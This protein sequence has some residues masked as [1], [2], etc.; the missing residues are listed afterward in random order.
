MEFMDFDGFSMDFDGFSMDSWMD[1]LMDCLMDLNGLF[2][3][4]KWGIV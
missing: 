2:K 4:F 1:C 3:G